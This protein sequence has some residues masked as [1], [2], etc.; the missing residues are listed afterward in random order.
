LEERVEE[1]RDDTVGGESR[2]G[3]RKAVGRLVEETL[4]V[5]AGGLTL[6]PTTGK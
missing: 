6:D 2:R 3:E 4:P 5:A 1:V